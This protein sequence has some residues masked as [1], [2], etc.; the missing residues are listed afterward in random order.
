[1]Y[2]FLKYFYRYDT[3][4]CATFCYT[5]ELVLQSPLMSI[6]FESRVVDNLE[7]NPGFFT[8]SIKYTTNA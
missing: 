1:M 2:Y 7:Y 8:H 5:Y 4:E 6:A 3:V